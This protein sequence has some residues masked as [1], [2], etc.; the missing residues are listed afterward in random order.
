M[1]SRNTLDSEVSYNRKRVAGFLQDINDDTE[2]VM[3]LY[4]AVVKKP[5]IQSNE[6]EEIYPNLLDISK[7]TIHQF[8]SYKKSVYDVRVREYME[9]VKA[10]NELQAITEFTDEDLLEYNALASLVYDHMK[11]FETDVTLLRRLKER[12]E[13]I[14]KEAIKLNRLGVVKENVEDFKEDAE[15]YLEELKKWR[16]S[17]VDKGIVEFIKRNPLTAL[18][19]GGLIYWFFTSGTA[20]ETVK[21]GTR[22]A[23][24]KK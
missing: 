17:P 1:K 18:A 6:F 13:G 23:V 22:A 2:R 8:D 11:N 9:V 20:K 10:I 14:Y 3:E 7:Q 24:K 4:D 19:I 5:Q 15:D 12:Y 16:D 21:I